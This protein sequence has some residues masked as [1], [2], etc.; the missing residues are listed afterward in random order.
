MLKLFG[1]GKTAETK[2]VVQRRSPAEIHL[3]RNLSE[4]ELESNMKMIPHGDNMFEFSITITPQEGFYRN[5]TIK[6]SFKVLPSFP[7]NPPK[8]KCETKIFHPNIDLEGNVCL[9]ILRE[10]W[11]PIL[12]IQQ[13]VLGLHFILLEPNP[14]DPLNKEAAQLQR[15]NLQEFISTVSSTLRGYSY[16][17]ES[18][19]RLV[20]FY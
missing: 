9:N 18:F 1:G 5:A 13:I 11:T 20:N 3:Q 17:G 15:N 4:L 12:S 14:D 8:V 19:P 6:F 16:K 10:D 7:N 2:V